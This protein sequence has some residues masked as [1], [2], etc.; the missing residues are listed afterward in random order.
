M[1]SAHCDDGLLF[2]LS[3]NKNIFDGN[4]VIEQKRF[5]NDN[6]KG[7][8]SAGGGTVLFLYTSSDDAL[9]FVPSFIK[10]FLIVIQL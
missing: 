3:F 9:F 2:V 10:I 8:K 5:H 1:F 7:I 4:K 6:S